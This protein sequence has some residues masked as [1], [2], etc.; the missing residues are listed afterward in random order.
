MEV[1]APYSVLVVQGLRVVVVVLLYAFVIRLGW[2]LR[3]TLH[4]TAQTAAMLPDELVPTLVVVDVASG[5]NGTPELV[6]RRYPLGISNLIGRDPSNSIAIPDP[7]VSRQH[8]RL[9]FR[10]GEWWIEDL[11]SSNGTLVEGSAV[12][13]PVPMLPDEVFRIGQVSLA[14]R[15]EPA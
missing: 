14:V 6:G 8:A 7:Y 13:E 11:A 9:D 2:M 12:H 10:D 15:E 3:G 5:A 4:A 1:L